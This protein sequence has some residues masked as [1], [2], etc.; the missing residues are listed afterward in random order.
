M[1][2]TR[3][4]AICLIT[5]I[6]G[7]VLLA[8]YFVTAPKIAEYHEI[9][10]KKSVLDIFNIPYKTENKEIFGFKY[11]KIDKKDIR[12]VFEKNITIGKLPEAPDVKQ[13]EGSKKGKELFKYYKDGELQGI[14]FVV[15][16]LGYGFNKAAE[17]SLF[18]CVDKDLE[19]IKGIDVLDHAETPGLGGR[20]IEDEFKRQFIGKKLKP[21]ISL[22]RGKATLGPN[23]VH[24]ITGA[25][26]TSKGIENIINEAMNIFWQEM[27]SKK[28]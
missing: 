8:L 10:L 12:R 2:L 7:T 21:K 26:Y 17:I 14:G 25:S 4:A 15:T 28:G 20:M 1:I 13:Q 11:K 18:I 6:P 27:E 23:E 3:S 19:T 24:A 5:A 22:V 16:R 9:K